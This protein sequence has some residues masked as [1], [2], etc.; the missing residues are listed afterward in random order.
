MQPSQGSP[1]R[2]IS[3]GPYFVRLAAK[4]CGDG[5]LHPGP[6]H[7]QRALGSAATEPSSK[8][9]VRKRQA[10]FPDGRFDVLYVPILRSSGD[11]FRAQK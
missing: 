5:S 3:A 10:G 1:V 9:E 11:G 7:T 2:R 8:A 4:V 6:G